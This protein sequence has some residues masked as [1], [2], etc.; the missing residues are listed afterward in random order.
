M[1]DLNKALSVVWQKVDFL[2]KGGA[3]FNGHICVSVFA[4]AGEFAVAPESFRRALG[5]F[6][7][8]GILSLSTWRYDVWREVDWHE[9]RSEDFFHNPHDSN[10]VRLRLA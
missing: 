10:Y 3:G 9:W 8:A 7:D 6:A 4:L 1:N 5:T 2:R